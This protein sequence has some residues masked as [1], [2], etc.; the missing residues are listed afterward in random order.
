MTIPKKFASG[1][2]IRS[3]RRAQASPSGMPIAWVSMMARNS[4]LQRLRRIGGDD[5]DRFEQR[6]ARLDAANDHVDGVRQRLEKVLFPALLEIAQ[7]P[8]RQAEAGGEGEARGGK[9]SAPDQHRHRKADGRENAGNDHEFLGRPVQPGL[10]E[11]AAQRDPAFLL[12]ARLE[13]LQRPFDLFAARA[14]VLV[15]AAGGRFRLRDRRAAAL[16][17]P[18][19]RQQGIDKDPCHAADGGGGE[20]GQCERLYLH[21]ALL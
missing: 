2:G 6:Q 18:L 9:Q 10:R 13:I 20:K 7:A 8:A 1:T 21:G 17:L 19:P 15:G 3:N 4:L 16:G 14:L 5:L 11:A 12:A